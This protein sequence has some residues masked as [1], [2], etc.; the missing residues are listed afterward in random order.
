MAAVVLAV[1]DDNVCQSPMIARVLRSRMPAEVS[2]AGVHAVAGEQMDPYARAVLSRMGIDVTGSASRPLTEQ[3]VGD[4]DLVVTATRQQRSALLHRF[5][6]ALRRSFT[7]LEFADL[8]TVAQGDTFGEI[9]ASAARK[10]GSTPIPYRG[11]AELDLPDP[12]SMR[13]RDYQIVADRIVAAADLIA[14]R[15]CERSQ[16]THR[17]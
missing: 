17:G 9:V 4:A 3:Q 1:C 5:P 10:R 2:S 15:L 6:G 16:P 8:L 14:E 13:E 11:G 12:A 7:L